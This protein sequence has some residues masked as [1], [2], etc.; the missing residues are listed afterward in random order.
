M[1]FIIVKNAQRPIWKH[2]FDSDPQ[3]GFPATMSCH[4]SYS[5]VQCGILD[6]YS[7]YGSAVLACRKINDF[8]PL[9]YYAVCPEDIGLTGVCDD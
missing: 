9:G 7:D 1:S 6:R 2:Y 5:G 8:N 4:T 3:K